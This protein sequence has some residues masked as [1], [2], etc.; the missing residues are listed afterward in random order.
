MVRF[1]KRGENVL[2]IVRRFSFFECR[3][4]RDIESEL[5]QCSRTRPQWEISSF[6]KT[7]DQ[8]LNRYPLCTPTKRRILPPIILCQ[9]KPNSAVTSDMVREHVGRELGSY[10]KPSDVMFVTESLPRTAVGKISRR[11]ARD[12]YLLNLNCVATR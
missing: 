3:A 9:V 10:M 2:A 7:I 1:M 12:T 4:S 8:A 6:P 5:S 11:V